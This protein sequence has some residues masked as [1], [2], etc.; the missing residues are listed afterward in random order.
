MKKKIK[1]F[2][3]AIAAALVIGAAVLPAAASEKKYPRATG[4]KITLPAAR[5]TSA[6]ATAIFLPNRSD[7]RD[8]TPI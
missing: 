7:S 2:S 8:A 4:L 6:A 5:P 3:L 1:L